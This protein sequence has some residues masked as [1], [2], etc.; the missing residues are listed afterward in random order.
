MKYEE[1]KKKYPYLRIH[2]AFDPNNPDHSK[3]LKWIREY[4]SA[5]EIKLATATVRLLKKLMELEEKQSE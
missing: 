1:W 3:L 2:T 5:E 4:A